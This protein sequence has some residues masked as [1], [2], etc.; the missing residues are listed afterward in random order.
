MRKIFL[1]VLAALIGLSGPI[2]ARSEQ[3]TY[4]LEIHTVEGLNQ[5]LRQ[6]M[7]V[8][9]PPLLE[10]GQKWHSL[11]DGLH[12]LNDLITQMPRVGEFQLAGDSLE[13][14]HTDAVR[15]RSDFSYWSQQVSLRL[16][17]IE[18]L[19]SEIDQVI[20]RFDQ[21]WKISLPLHRAHA[22]SSATVRGRLARIKRRLKTL[23]SEINFRVEAIERATLLAIEEKRHQAEQNVID[24]V[25]KDLDFRNQSF[26]FRDLISRLETKLDFQLSV[27]K[28]RKKS[29][30][31]SFGLQWMR[32]FA[33]PV[34][35][36]SAVGAE[37][38]TAI[39]LLE[40]DLELALKRISELTRSLPKSSVVSLGEDSQL[41]DPFGESMLFGRY[42]CSSMVERSRVNLVP[43]LVSNGGPTRHH[44]FSQDRGGVSVRVAKISGDQ[45][46]EIDYLYKLDWIFGF[47]GQKKSLDELAISKLLVMIEETLADEKNSGRSGEMEWASLLNLRDR[48]QVLKATHQEALR[49]FE[50]EARLLRTSMDDGQRATGAIAAELSDSSYAFGLE[51]LDEVPRL[52]ESEFRKRNEAIVAAARE[53]AFGASPPKLKDLLL[54]GSQVIKGVPREK[55]SLKQLS[56]SVLGLAVIV[57]LL[58]LS[59]NQGRS[60]RALAEEA[61]SGK[62]NADRLFQAVVALVGSGS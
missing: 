40:A 21:S 44:L 3:K 57:D 5:S 39:R 7:I 46:L 38:V 59:G 49:T 12:Q 2:P 33:V 16:I 23:S 56:E 15:A 37:Q 14:A 1:P 53:V 9:R 10:I 20:L 24:Q 61:R 18:A 17:S 48:V 34:L 25:R 52:D 51:S 4:G 29:E 55:G 31:L 41:E 60:L 43:S 32:L 13:K 19:I 42:D 11:T 6:L 30:E 47:S 27:A 22:E 36:A 62:V 8:W 50:S 35:R 58:D 28:N 26:F 54:F 45:D